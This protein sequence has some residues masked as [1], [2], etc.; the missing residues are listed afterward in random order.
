[1]MT[2]P[3]GTPSDVKNDLQLGTGQEWHPPVENDVWY[4]CERS[5]VKQFGEI[6]RV[7]HTV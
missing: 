3:A 2:E 1:M 4:R 5:I 6:A 7:S